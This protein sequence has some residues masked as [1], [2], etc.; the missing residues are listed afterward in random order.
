MHGLQ[1]QLLTINV[2][3]L[4]EYDIYYKMYFM[5]KFYL[6]VKDGEAI[7]T[8][9]AIDIDEAIDYFAKIKQMNIDDLLNLFI[10]D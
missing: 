5:K 2:N 9:S 4:K 8:V 7:N 1:V 3:F 10:V 6:K